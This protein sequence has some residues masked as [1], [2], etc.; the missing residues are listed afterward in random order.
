MNPN[1]D[2]TLARTIREHNSRGVGLGEQGRLWN[3]MVVH[4]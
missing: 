4:L 2:D 3:L 1:D